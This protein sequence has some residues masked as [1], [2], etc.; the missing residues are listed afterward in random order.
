[1]SH[2]ELLIEIK[3]KTELL[4]SQKRNLTKS[5]TALKN[6]I[7]RLK[8]ITETNKAEIEEVKGKLK[9]VKMAKTLNSVN[10]KSTDS[11]YKINQLVKEIDK[12]ISML[13][14]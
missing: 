5:N 11:K 1:M 4:V 10:E 14:S 2:E 8:S 6:E 7:A 9:I 3:S 13:N 12:C